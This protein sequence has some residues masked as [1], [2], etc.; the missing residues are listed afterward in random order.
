MRRVEDASEANERQAQSLDSFQN[1]FVLYFEKKG[2]SMKEFT[3]EKL[4]R[5]AKAVAALKC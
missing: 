5:G 2:L 4:V 3:G 1:S